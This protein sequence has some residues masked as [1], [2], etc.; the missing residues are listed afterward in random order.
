MIRPFS[1]VELVSVVS[2][3][4]DV[5][6]LQAFDGIVFVFAVLIPV[7]VVAASVYNLEH[8]KSFS[9]PNIG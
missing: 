3:I 9:S 2:K 7:P 1:E 4:L 6:E 8:P 5:A